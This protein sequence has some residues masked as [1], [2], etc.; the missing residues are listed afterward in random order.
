[1]IWGLDKKSGAASIHRFNPSPVPP[2]MLKQSDATVCFRSSL[3]CILPVFSSGKVADSWPF[4][5]NHS[6][7][8]PVNAGFDSS[9]M[10][11]SAALWAEASDEWKQWEHWPGACYITQRVEEKIR[12]ERIIHPTQICLPPPEL[13]EPEERSDSRL[14]LTQ[15]NVQ[16]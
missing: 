7:S 14:K 16:R 1:M 6:R 10:C 15:R 3:G 2:N 9:S 11:V 4:W 13:Q 12:A 8:V 5:S